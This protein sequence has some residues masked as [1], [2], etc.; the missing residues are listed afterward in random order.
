MADG[1]GRNP[2][3]LTNNPANDRDPA[4]SPDGTQIAFS[5]GLET[6]EEG[7]DWDVVIPSRMY[8]M[9]AD[10]A[11]RRAITDDSIDP[12]PPADPNATYS[13]A[14]TGPTWSPDGSQLTV[15]VDRDDRLPAR[16]A[17]PSRSTRWIRQAADSPIELWSHSGRWSVRWSP[18]GTRRGH[19]GLQRCLVDRRH[20]R[21]GC[22]WHPA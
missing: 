3:R 9:D 22:G 8:V 14:H 6:R 12:G 11:N 21:C 4:W 18:D 17:G 15:V 10:G 1:D 13:V 7:A 19:R 16:S 2:V 5:S 20:H